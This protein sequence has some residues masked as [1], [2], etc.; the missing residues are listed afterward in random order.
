M[1][2]EK[3]AGL[4]ASEQRWRMNRVGILNFWYYDEEEFEM[5]DGRLILRGANG[6]GKS[7]TMQSFLPLVLDGD[8]RPHRLDPFGSRDRRIEYY[9]LGETD[10]GKSDVTGYLWMEFIHPAKEVYKTIGIGLRARRGAAQ[11]QFWGFVLEDG[12][13]IGHNFWLYDHNYSMEHNVRVPL[14]RR[15]LEEKIGV[16]GQVVHDQTSYRDLVNKQLFGFAETDAYQDLL[17]LMIQLRSPKLSKDFKPSAIYDILHR[18]LPPLQEDEL[19]PLSEVLED[20]DQI[21]DGLDEVRLHRKEI[22]RLQDMYDRYNKQ[23]IYVKSID[24]LDKNAKYDESR[25]LTSEAERALQE[26]EDEKQQA[27]DEMNQIEGRLVELAAEIE[28]LENHEAIGK[29]RELEAATDALRDAEKHLQLTRERVE[30]HQARMTRLEQDVSDTEHKY[31]DMNREQKSALDELE[32]MAQEAEFVEHSV[33]HR[34]WDRG[35]PVDDG[36]REPWRRDLRDHR[37][38][39]EQA[40]DKAR[41]EREAAGLVRELELELGEARKERDH[42]ERE[43]G[44]CE[45]Q[46]EQSKEELREEIVMWRNGLSTLAFEDEHIRLA[47]GAISE[48]GIE[49]RAY[50]PVRAPVLEVFNEQREQLANERLG[51]IQERRGLEQEKTRLEDEKTAWEQSREPEPGRNEARAKARL[52]R[53]VRSGA[54][55]FAVCDFQSHLDEGAKARLEEALERSG[56]LDA[57]ISPDGEIGT[58]ADDHEE[59]WIVPQPHEI[60]YTLADVLI[61]SP[62]EE[63][64]LQASVIDTVLRTFLWE[65]SGEVT[66]YDSAGGVLSAKGE[67]RLG[68]MVGSSRTKERAEYIGKETRKRTRMLEIARLQREVDQLQEQIAALDKALELLKER[69]QLLRRECDL[70]PDGARVHRELQNLLEAAFR[71]EAIMKQE[72]RILER[73]KL[74]STEWRELQRQLVELTAA[75]SRLKRENDLREAVAVCREYDSVIGELYSAWRRGREATEAL[76]RFKEELESVTIILEEE[77][78]HQEQLEE[79]RKVLRTQVGTLRSVI[80][81][82]GLTDVTERIEIIK[83]EQRNITQLRKQGYQNLDDIK[84]KT[85]TLKE[86][87]RN[88]NGQLAELQQ[89]M[90]LSAGQW[91]REAGRALVAE[92]RGTY[93]PE[94]DLLQA[95]K[96]A[97]EMKQRYDSLFANRNVETVT[98]NLLEHYNAV[99]IILTDY[100]LETIVEEDTGRIL[101]QSMRDRSRPQPPQVL[102]EELQ[103]SEEEQSLLLSEKDRELYEEIILR[104]VGKSIRQRIHRAE[105]WVKQMNR[106]MEERNTSSGLRLK[107]EWE[108]KPA[109][110]EQEMDTAMLVELLKRDTHRLRED[111]ID[112][113]IN[114]FRS[115]ISFAKQNAQEEQESLRKHLFEVLDYRNWFQFELRYRKGDQA[116]YRPLTDSR[117]NVL[118]GGEK[119]MA[120]YIPLFAA[121]WSRYSDARSDAPRLISLD[122]AFAGVD[123]E[124]MRDMFKLLT[125]MGFDYM[126]TSQ[127]LWGCYDTVPKL[128]IYEIYRPKDVDFVTLFRYRWNGKI[129]EYVQD[130]V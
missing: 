35:M 30:Q 87:L 37:E 19:R 88:Y 94:M 128:A 68:P 89:G 20:M 79:R 52:E 113:M 16:G 65:E 72:Q 99:R 122:E 9:L 64:G 71:L 92:W 39:L 29:Q 42:A 50:E 41:E 66:A 86:R 53:Q 25:H 57:W 26:A 59:F 101:I 121:T 62:S 119:A 82:L 100:V 76:F 36:W 102:L 4:P 123:E 54:P 98:S 60:G 126:M 97:K 7:V 46:L 51:M 63:S 45:K 84:E 5:E 3:R 109:K 111:E 91:H 48:Y 107:L 27:Q 32:T 56:L 127:V 96:L 44:V 130:G 69:E 74:K 10:S 75:W 38:S 90:E 24:L 6:S 15:E 12:R 17:Q 73:Y 47:F 40:L 80:E 18:A 8:K 49:H 117:F 118:S 116:G 70:F 13:R 67:F 124:N 114:H 78:E 43:R 110:N 58:I 115:Q 1:A 31:E 95:L 11:V 14:G 104:S 105:G 83:G 33:Y 125:D 22:S 103:R 93:D 77:E 21:S 34:F 129:K 81:E 61:P 106:L 28:V 112:L 85:A 108:P 120:M 55:L 23:M 2:D